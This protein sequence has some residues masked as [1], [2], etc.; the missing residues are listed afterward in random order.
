MSEDFCCEMKLSKVCAKRVA[1]RL[2]SAAT[3]FLQNSA[4]L[5]RKILTGARV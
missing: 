4:R 5:R 1:D 2:P 3:D